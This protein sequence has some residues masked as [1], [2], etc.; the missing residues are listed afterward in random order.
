MSTAQHA[1]QRGTLQFTIGSASPRSPSLFAPRP[2]GQADNHVDIAASGHMLCQQ[3][4]YT[5][6]NPQGYTKTNLDASIN[7]VNM[8]TPP[9]HRLMG[10]LL[11]VRNGDVCE[12]TPYAP[13]FSKL[14]QKGTHHRVIVPQATLGAT[15]VCIV[16]A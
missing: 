12:R 3:V 2:G 5:N 8:A 13:P 1:G 10:H 7:H 6:L 16:S 14:N 9:L 11:C 15:P 4:T